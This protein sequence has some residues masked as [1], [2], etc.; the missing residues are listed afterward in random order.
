[1]VRL[2][3]VALAAMACPL[4]ARA[5]QPPLPLGELAKPGRLLMLRHAHAPGFGDPPNFVIGDCSTQRNLDASG[6]AQARELG[7]R[8]RAVGLAKRVSFRASGAARAKRP[9][10][11]TLGRWSPCPR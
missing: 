11:S 1:M 6:R 8:L 7:A 4:L 5:D 3:I 9:A 10:Y 2:L